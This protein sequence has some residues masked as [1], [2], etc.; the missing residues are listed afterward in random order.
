MYKVFSCHIL[1]MFILT[2]YTKI[3]GKHAVSIKSHF[4]SNG[5]NTF[6]ICFQK[7]DFDSI[8]DSGLNRSGPTNCFE[9][10]TLI[11]CEFQRLR[12]GHYSHPPS[13]DESIIPQIIDLV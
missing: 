8:H 3:G 12:F 6:A 10:I 13:A 11:L 7:N 1:M 4:F 2:K 5:V 9:V